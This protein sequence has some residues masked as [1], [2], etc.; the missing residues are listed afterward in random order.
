M[1]AIKS[2]PS[3]HI[4]ISLI[5]VWTP[6]DPKKPMEEPPSP[7]LITEI[8]ELEIVDSYRKLIGTASVKFPRGTVIKKT[9]TELNS[10]EIAQNSVVSANVD[11]GILVTTRTNSKLA[12]TAD[13]KIG[14]RIRIMLG[15]TTDPKVAALAKVDSSGKSLHND[16]DKLTEYKKHLTTMFDGYIT[17]CSISTPIE[18]KC[19][20]LASRLKK[21]SCPKV[22][23]S[24]N[25]T[26]ND[27]LSDN[28]QWKL[29]KNSGL[30]LHPDTESCDINIGKVSLT[31]DLTIADVLTEWSKYK[32]FAY[33]K[34]NNEEPCIA[35]GR[36]YFS[37]AGKDSIIQKD[38]SDIPIILFNYHVADDDLTLMNTD[39]NFL[40]VE[41]TSLETNSKF[42]HITI[43]KNPDYD[44]TNPDSKKWQ[45]LNETTISKKA[46]KCGA[47][48]LKR[49]KDKVDLSQYTII[50]YM[51]RKIGI[52]H[53]DLLKEAIQYFESYNMNGVDGSLTIFGDL[54][55]KSGVKV[56][57]KDDRFTQRNG[58]YLVDEVTTKFGVS[59]FRQTIKLP[60]LISR[61]KNTNEE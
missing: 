12:D 3:F 34:Y 51:S 8:E 15:Y 17:K 55:L 26:V 32:V 10:E 11:N 54:K 13:F 61:K 41:A 52:S 6:D 56:E 53:E 4:L 43:R 42:Y 14:D 60:Y 7:R 50:P 18:I 9:I 45:V 48:V 38:S 2:Q 40:A 22:K 1:A 39:K 57:L 58:Y 33:V 16:T 23:A 49:S 28:G 25:M 27:L 29:L 36:S 44:S 30:K 21:I 59:G 24:K 46:Q 37:N 31:P 35:V 19:E 5:Q 47:T 20:N